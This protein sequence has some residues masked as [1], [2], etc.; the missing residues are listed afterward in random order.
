[1]HIHMLKQLKNELQKTH[2]C[3]ELSFEFQKWVFQF[4]TDYSTILSLLDREFWRGMHYF[5]FYWK[6]YFNKNVITISWSWFLNSLLYWRDLIV[7]SLRNLIYQMYP[8]MEAFKKV[9]SS[10]ISK[11]R[12]FPLENF[13]VCIFI[14][15]SKTYDSFSNKYKYKA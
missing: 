15:M 1:M 13:S 5:A 11:E 3:F 10:T 6:L 8:E 9:C 4:I 12:L 7:R 14:K 2:H